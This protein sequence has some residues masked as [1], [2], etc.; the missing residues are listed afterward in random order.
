MI[1][2][3][4]ESAITSIEEA[5]T[6]NISRRSLYSNDRRPILRGRNFRRLNT[7]SITIN[8]DAEKRD[9]LTSERINQFAT[10]NA[11]EKSVDEGCAICIDGVEMNKMMIKLD[12]SHFYCNECIRKWLEKNKNCP[13]CKKEFKN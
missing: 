1:N 12:C 6:S 13:L 2:E 9:G 5:V 7:P 11:D 10:F 4:L 3:T 8:S